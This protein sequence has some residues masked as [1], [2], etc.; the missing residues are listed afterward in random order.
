M[1]VRSEMVSYTEPETRR[2][3]FESDQETFVKLV[4]LNSARFSFSFS[5]FFRVFN[6]LFFSAFFPAFFV[7]FQVCLNCSMQNIRHSTQ[8]SPSL[9]VFDLL[10]LKQNTHNY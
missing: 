9:A 6:L 1:S 4:F 8:T 3:E 7:C 2:H 10:N 5:F